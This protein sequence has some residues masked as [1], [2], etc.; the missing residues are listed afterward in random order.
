MPSPRPRMLSKNIRFSARVWAK[1][2]ARAAER[3]QTPSE[4]VRRLVEREVD[5]E[6]PS[7]PG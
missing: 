2:E 4:W 1:V 3:E 7:P 5:D 6:R